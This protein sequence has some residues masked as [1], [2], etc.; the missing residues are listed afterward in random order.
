MGIA[1]RSPAEARPLG[2]VKRAHVPAASPSPMDMD[3]A[4]G[5]AASPRGESRRMLHVQYSRQLQVAVEPTLF[6]AIRRGGRRLVNAHCGWR[7]F[8]MPSREL[9]ATLQTPLIDG[10]SPPLCPLP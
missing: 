6:A 1:D 7:W 10:V 2:R 4:A 5:S 9:A 3:I 8:S